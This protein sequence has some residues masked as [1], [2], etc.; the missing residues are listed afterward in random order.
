M[1]DDL[2]EQMKEAEF[3]AYAYMLTICSTASSYALERVW[4]KSEDNPTFRKIVERSLS[5]RQEDPN[6]RVDT[7]FYYMNALKRGT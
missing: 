4:H 6:S 3:D 1:S 2:F 7:H 5:R